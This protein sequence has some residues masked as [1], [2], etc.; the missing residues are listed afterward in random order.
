MAKKPEIVVSPRYCLRREDWLEAA[1]NAFLFTLP[2]SIAF[3]SALQM[4]F[5]LKEA[6]IAY[7]THLLSIILDIFKKWN[8]E[9]TYLK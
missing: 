5:S 8:K 3:I 9:S 2:A 7:Y 1:K 4:G 6:A